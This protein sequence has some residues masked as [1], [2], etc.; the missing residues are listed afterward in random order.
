MEFMGNFLYFLVGIFFSL[1]NLYWLL[2]YKVEIYDVNYG[3]YLVI[4][5][6]KSNE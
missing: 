2:V 3:N 5:E 6:D 1:I 4:F